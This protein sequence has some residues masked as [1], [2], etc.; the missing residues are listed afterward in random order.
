MTGLSNSPSDDG[1]KER[2]RSLEAEFRE[3]FAVDGKA[4][5]RALPV[6][7]AY[8][9]YYKTF[10]KS[11]HVQ[12]QTESVALGNRPLPSV[13]AVVDSMFMAELRSGLLTA[14]HDLDS[15]QPPVT[16]DVADGSESYT[17][18]GGKEQT[19]KAGDM[20][21]R[22]ALGVISNVLYGPDARTPISMQTK[23]AMF[24]VYAPDGISKQAVEQ[25]LRAIQQALESFSPQANTV[26]LETFGF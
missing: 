18:L 3:R 1:L 6:M 25:H 8:A 24:A 26:M 20:Y 5:I 14:G 22:D 19:L 13:S 16:I 10:G 12:M 17:A 15:I 9:A 7:Q 11:Y 23:A 21:M 4:A 2:Q